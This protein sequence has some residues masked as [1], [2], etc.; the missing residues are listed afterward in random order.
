MARLW[1][2]MLVVVALGAFGVARLIAR[3][4]DPKGYSGLEFAPVTEAG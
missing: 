4:P 2:G 1:L 3:S